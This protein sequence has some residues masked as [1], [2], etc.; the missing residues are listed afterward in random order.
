MSEVLS[1]Y[2]SGETKITSLQN[3]TTAG[4]GTITSDALDMEGY[5]AVLFLTSF[6]TPAVNNLIT[7]HDSAA[8]GS[9]FAATVAL[10]ACSA[11][12]GMVALDVH[13]AVQR[14]VK[15][16]ATRGTSSTCET[17]WGIQYNAKVKPVTNTATL[18]GTFDAPAAA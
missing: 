5:D 1:G 16:V 4:T 12:V 9:G 14:Y 17:I 2:I 11:S 3:H 8:S 6:G 15:C 18:P 13:R 10:K 7:M